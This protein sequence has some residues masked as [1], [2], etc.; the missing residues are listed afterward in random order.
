MQPSRPFLRFTL[1]LVTL[2]LFNSCG[3]GGSGIPVTAMIGPAGG[4][5]SSAD[6]RLT[7]LIPAGALGEATE[8]SIRPVNLSELGSEFTDIAPIR[9]Y[10]LEPDGLTFS[11][12]ITVEFDL[13]TSST[14]SNG[15]LEAELFLAFTS[16]NGVL[17]LPDNQVISVDLDSGRSIFSSELAHFSKLVLSSEKGVTITVS[18]VPG[19]MPVNS[20][21]HITSFANSLIIF[22]KC[23]LINLLSG[24]NSS[25]SFVVVIFFSFAYSNAFFISSFACSTLLVHF[26]LL[27]S[28]FS[29][30][31]F[32]VVSS[33]GSI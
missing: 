6:R 33:S 17:E 32:H 31:W 28:S 27:A 4:S 23:I 22:A 20:S 30:S 21:F 3:G 9:A 14:K 7:L 25:K 15:D 5:V 8:I 11:T 2:F 10:Q 19:S 16:S 1:I 26:P 24:S 18:G 13:Q 12:P 29:C